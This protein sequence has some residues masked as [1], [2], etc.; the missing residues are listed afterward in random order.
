VLPSPAK[1]PD[2]NIIENVWGYLARKVYHNAR[3]FDCV[4]DLKK[5][6]LESWNSIDDEYLRN[7]YDSVQ[8]R[9]VEV[10]ERK[11]SKTNY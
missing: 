6:I 9:L 8:S 10:L 5:A 4:A 7:L 2:L 3:Q 1:S 11:G